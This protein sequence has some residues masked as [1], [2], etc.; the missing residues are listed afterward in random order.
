MT[1]SAPRLLT[2]D[3]V[4]RFITDGFLILSPDVPGSVHE[5]IDER[6]LWLLHKEGNPGNNVLPIVPEMYE[7]LNSPVIRGALASIL[8]P[9]YVMHPHRYVH[10]N[11]PGKIDDSGTPKVGEGSHSFVGWHQDDHSPLSRPR[12]H[13]PRYAMILYYPQD[14]PIERG[15]TQ[16]IPATQLSRS[17]SEADRMRGLQAAGTAGTC[18]LAHFDIVHGGSLNLSDRTRNMV[19]F[20][21]ARCSDPVSPSWDNRNPE[22]I[23]PDTHL[24]PVENTVLWRHQWEWMSGRVPTAAC[25]A[26]VESTSISTHTL[27]SQLSGDSIQQRIDIGEQLGRKRD[28]RAISALIDQ[29]SAEE[30]VR[31]A[32]IYNVALAG[33]AAV[34][35]L[36]TALE[37]AAA[38]SEAAG[39]GSRWN[40]GAV[41]MED[42]AYALAAI[43]LPAVSK[44]T[45]LL[46]SNS[47]WVR[48]NA[49]F[50]LGEMGTRAFRTMPA[51]IHLLQD[52]S[53]P[54]VRTVL[55]AIGQ[56]SIGAHMAVPEIKRLLAEP[57]DSFPDTWLAPQ[58]R[59]W[60]GLGQVRLN[61]VMALLRL[62]SE[63]NGVEEW[64]GEFLDDDCGYVGGFGIEFLMRCKTPA[65]QSATLE[66]LYRHRWDSTL[67]GG[68]RTF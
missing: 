58:T 49:A 59:K 33:K 29:F 48:I 61:A 30:P 38:K 64:L 7:V 65:A 26:Q 47:E 24:S 44:L 39:S 40:E 20:V 12:H 46:N 17:H 23:S 8:G 31:Q 53:H 2:D 50:A 27:L 28:L 54:V 67:R 18:V 42:A 25:A 10:N 45:T 57:N 3:E 1:A 62:G 43:G 34:N 5:R 9:D 52:D 32:A 16:I 41:V 14:T 66:Y 15:P 11:E 60:T 21:F 6:L 55:D 56:I 13:Y 4:R 68:V 63:A 22:W 51:L 19:K 37:A 35:P 36:C